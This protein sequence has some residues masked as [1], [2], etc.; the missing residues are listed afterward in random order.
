MSSAACR[1]A[2]TQ[3]ARSSRHRYYQSRLPAAA[4]LV[5][6][7]NQILHVGLSASWCEV[8]VLPSSRLGDAGDRL[9]HTG[10]TVIAL[11]VKLFA[12]VLEKRQ[13][14]RAETKQLGAGFHKDSRTPGQVL[15]T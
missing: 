2:A 13:E 3:T 4:A 15:R 7:F 12:M 5:C 6:L 8:V 9:N 10:N 1:A 11:L 14:D